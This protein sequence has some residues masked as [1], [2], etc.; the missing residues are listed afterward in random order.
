MQ[1]QER[2]EE[3]TVVWTVLG[4]LTAVGRGGSFAGPFRRAMLDRRQ[5]IV[6]DLGGVS[7]VD[8]GGLG[9]L[10]TAHVRARE[11]GI[12]FQLLNVPTRLCHLLELTKLATVMPVVESAPAAARFARSG[13]V[14]A[15]CSTATRP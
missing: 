2:S 13:S 9:L 6:L 1:I 15:T 7:L 3:E 12:A 5:A 11:H 4:P 8:A 14:S 10:V